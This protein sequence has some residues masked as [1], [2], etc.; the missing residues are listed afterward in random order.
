M[1]FSV[2]HFYAASTSKFRAQLT[3]W[4]SEW[5]FLQ[6]TPTII[7]LPSVHAGPYIVAIQTI[8]IT[9][10]SIPLC[11]HIVPCSNSLCSLPC[12][13]GPLKPPGCLHA[14]WPKD[15][16]F[17]MCSR[18]AENKRKSKHAGKS[19]N[20]EWN[21]TVIYKNIHLEQVRCSFMICVSNSRPNPAGQ[22]ILSG[23]WG[24]AETTIYL[25]LEHF[26]EISVWLPV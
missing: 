6:R 20:P 2:P 25:Q 14:R 4:T 9:S 3:W 5:T 15:F 22:F 23:L 19:L 8:C 10:S 12:S 1:P 17:L 11:C 24:R 21:Q 26:E 18:S 16:Y 13:G 7:S